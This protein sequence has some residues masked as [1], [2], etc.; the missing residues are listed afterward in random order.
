MQ[1]PKLLNLGFQSLTTH[2][3]L[4]VSTNH[5]RPPLDQTPT[6][7][8]FRRTSM[9]SS[10]F[11]PLPASYHHMTPINQLPLLPPPT[12]PTLHH[13]TLRPQPTSSLMIDG[14][15]STSFLLLQ[16][17]FLSTRTPLRPFLP[18]S[19]AHRATGAPRLPHAQPPP[20]ALGSRT[21]APAPQ[22]PLARHHLQLHSNTLPQCILYQNVLRHHFIKPINYP[23]PVTP[24]NPCLRRPAGPTSKG[25]RSPR[26]HQQHRQTST[27]PT[28]PWPAHHHVPT[29][30]QLPTTSPPANIAPLTNL[31]PPSPVVTLHPTTTQ[32]DAQGRPLPLHQQNY[33]PK[34]DPWHADNH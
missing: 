14:S 28:H 3:R 15:M 11:L 18:L 1:P 33:D 6:T 8:T 9:P 19:A 26:P 2:S 20:P 31:A 22:S 23:P 17:P 32:V 25:V 5:S 21:H 10:S 34:T 7:A 24:Y 12:L 16:L 4:Q 30:Q 29:Q 13:P 27:P